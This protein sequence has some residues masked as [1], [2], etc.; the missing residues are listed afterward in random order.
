MYVNVCVCV[1]V[2]LRLSGRLPECL[3]TCPVD[4]T[5]VH[6]QACAYVCVSLFFVLCVYMGVLS[7]LAHSPAPRTRKIYFSPALFSV[8]LYNL[9]LLRELEGTSVWSQPYYLQGTV[10]GQACNPPDPQ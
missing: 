10:S 9:K 8:H 6:K 4:C 7:V 5:S 2:S 1:F 3:W